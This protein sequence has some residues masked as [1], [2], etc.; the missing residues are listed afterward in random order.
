MLHGID[1][2]VARRTTMSDPGTV[3]ARGYDDEANIIP[4][5]PEETPPQPAEAD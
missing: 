4:E 1:G 2:K 3:R 5:S